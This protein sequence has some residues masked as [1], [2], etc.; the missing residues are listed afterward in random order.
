MKPLV[1]AIQQ[2]WLA[3]L[4]VDLQAL[5]G[6]APRDARPRRSVAGTQAAPQSDAGPSLGAAHRLV[7]EKPGVASRSVLDALASGLAVKGRGAPVESA[8][9][10]AADE[11]P[12]ARSLEALSQAVQ[13]CTRCSR[14]AG[15]IRAVAGTGVDTQPWYFLVGEQPGLEDEAAGLPFQGQ[16]G[17]LLEA[18]L[19]SVSLPHRESC[20]RTHA[21]KCRA[22]GGVRPNGTEIAACRPWLRQQI[23][24][25]QPRWILALGRVATEAILGTEENF[26]SLRGRTSRYTLQSGETIPVRVTHLPSSLLVHAGLKDEAWRDLLGLAQAVQAQG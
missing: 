4:G 23:E 14:A 2:A 16:S 6:V 7:R 8:A 1:N 18:M 3:E 20:Y 9:A 22:P 11:I 26:E 13:G 25:L 21:V 12:C 17:Q 24:T 5:P 10:A 15:R 19:A